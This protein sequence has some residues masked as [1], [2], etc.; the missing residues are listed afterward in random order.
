[1]GVSGQYMTDEMRQLVLDEINVKCWE[2]LGSEQ[3]EHYA[4]LKLKLNLPALGKRLPEKV[5]EIIAA[6]KA[7]KWLLKNGSIL[8]ADAELL[9][10][11]Y[12]IILEPKAEF[13]GIAASLSDSLV[14]L[15]TNVTDEL[16]QEGLARDVVRIV[17]QLRKEAG[18]NVAD[19]IQLWF[20]TSDSE[21]Q[22]ALTNWQ[23]Y[24]SAQTLSTIVQNKLEIQ[25]A[26]QH[27]C[28]VAE[29]ALS[30][31]LYRTADYTSANF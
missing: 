12:E 19:R 28:T 18:L 2:N 5:R 31:A 24:I 30:V 15:D 17:Q 6:N 7:G 10:S 29:S 4:N 22:H 23:Q 3:I 27:E 26:V 14:L 25:P 9:Q 21:L 13:E 8:I 1:V 20:E 11:E 16:L